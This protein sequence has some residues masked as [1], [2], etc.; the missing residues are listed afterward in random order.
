ML[1]RADSVVA[2]LAGQVHAAD[3]VRKVHTYRTDAFSSG[4]AGPLG[5]VE[6]GKLIGL[7]TRHDVVKALQ[8]RYIEYLHETIQ[9]HHHEHHHAPGDGDAEDEE[10]F[11]E[12]GRRVV[13]GVPRG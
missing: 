1:P 3:R 13:D 7:T 9:R 8:G 4:D 11:L 6:E 12:H 5:V 2:V 10:Q